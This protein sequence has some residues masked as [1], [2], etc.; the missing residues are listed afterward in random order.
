MTKKRFW[1]GMLVIA[2]AFGMTV[3]GCGGDGDSTSYIDPTTQPGGSPSNAIDRIETIDLGTMTDADSGWQQLLSS[4]S[5][6]KKY[7]NL[8]LSACTMTGTSFKP[9]EVTG[10]IY[11]ASIILPNAATSIE[12]GT[13]SEGTF[14]NFYNLKS[15]KGTN[16]TT[17]DNYSFKGV[18]SLKNV[19]FTSVT[20]IGDDAFK[21]CRD[22]ESL[23]IPAV[24]QIGDYA[25]S[26]TGNT[27]LTI[28]MGSSAPNLGKQIFWNDTSL[29]KRTVKVK[30]PD[31]ATGYTPAASPFTGTSVTVSGTDTTVNWANGFRSKGW[32]G[33]AFLDSSVSIDSTITLIIEQK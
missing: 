21:G 24:T 29:E 8:D 31:G 14:F 3:I 30:V 4:I 19:D 10:L 13:S 32:T 1:L 15:I 6:T 25:F 16:I 11:I 20:T 17:I 27:T 12:A 23:N 26:N 28:T 33:S 22:L 2:L 9:G 7:V 5:S 18:S